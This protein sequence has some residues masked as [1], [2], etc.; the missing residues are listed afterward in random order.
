MARTG[1]VFAGV[2]L[3]AM[4]PLLACGPGGGDGGGTFADFAGA[5]HLIRTDPLTAC[6]HATRFE[7]P[8]LITQSGASLSLV[9][10][11]GTLAGTASA[12]TA[13]FPGPLVVP[14]GSPIIIQQYSSWALQRVGAVLRGTAT[15]TS[16]G[17]PS[18]TP[19]PCTAIANFSV[20]PEFRL[21][22]FNLDGVDGVALNQPL[23]FR[24]T[25]DVDPASFNPDTLEVVGGS[26]PFFEQFHADGD[27]LALLPSTVNFQDFSDSGLEPDEEYD[28]ILPAAPETNV[29]RSI[30][31]APLAQSE[32]MSFRT[33]TKVTFVEPR[34]LLIH[35][36]GPL[37]SPFGRGDEDGCLNEATNSLYVF[38][39]FQTGTDPSAMLLCLTNEGPPHVVPEQ[40]VPAHDARN[41]GEFSA[42]ESGKI[43]LPAVRISF[44]E[45]IYPTE[46]YAYD[47]PTQL[48]ANIQLWHV[49]DLDA[50]PI[51]VT[52]ANQVRT[53]RPLLVQQ[54]SRV[55]PPIARALL[56][57]IGPVS[58]GTYVVVVRSLTDLPGNALVT[59]GSPSPSVGGYG[60]IDA[61]I[62]G[63]VP[64]GYRYYFRTR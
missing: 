18:L 39:G 6:G 34:R 52:A 3:V 25:H 57:A 20:P 29:L 26:G 40:C 50:N 30:H 22:S 45:P 7:M 12:D 36:P 1:R 4:M 60:A 28:V 59:S 41:Q 16:L 35:A 38:P 54:G 11:Y 64:A 32:S 33:V 5:W 24:F 58:S 49:G 2:M 48:A 13:F 46:A 42:M 8:I 31:G 44:D 63:I 14:S 55:P 9:T 47:V 15:I 27:L 62:S 51:P 19:P 17:H 56:V 37:T 10:P 23:I 21:V 61:A 43:D 53:N